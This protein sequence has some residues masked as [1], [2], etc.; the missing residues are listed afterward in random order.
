MRLHTLFALLFLIAAGSVNAQLSLDGMKERASKAGKAVGE[1]T[2]SAVRAVGA[3]T[4][5]ATDAAKETVESTKKDLRDEATP[6]VTRAKLD[7]M[8]ETTLARLFADRPDS[9]ELF[10]RSVGYALFDTR[11]ASF[12]VVAGYGRGVAVDRRDDSRIYMK[13]AKTGA[14]LSFGFGGFD[15]QLVILFQDDGKFA[16][17]LSKGLD[18]SAQ[19]STMAARRRMSLH[20]SSP[21]AGLCSSL[22]RRVGRSQRS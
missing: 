7:A 6:E 2:G 9:R 18:A 16:E 17:F 11:E 22:P 5:K 20:C 1:T 15:S 14:G 19:V 8:A 3:A 4:G 21:K 12:Y 10:E 13:M